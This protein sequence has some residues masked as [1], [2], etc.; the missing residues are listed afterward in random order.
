MTLARLLL[1]RLLEPDGRRGRDVSASEGKR[2]Q[3]GYRRGQSVRRHGSIL[4]EG[5][6]QGG[7]LAALD[8]ADIAAAQGRIDIRLEQAADGS[9]VGWCALLLLEPLQVFLADCA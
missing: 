7:E 1:G 9:D 2:E 4:S 6:D 5:V 8:A 3:P